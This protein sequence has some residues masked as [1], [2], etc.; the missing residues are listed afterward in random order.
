MFYSAGRG[1]L[2]FARAQIVALAANLAI[3]RSRTRT[4]DNSILGGTKRKDDDDDDD[5]DKNER[6]SLVWSEQAKNT[7]KHNEQI[8]NVSCGFALYLYICIRSHWQPI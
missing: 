4:E 1:I 2:L 5:Q 7:H 3:R 8:S 6:K